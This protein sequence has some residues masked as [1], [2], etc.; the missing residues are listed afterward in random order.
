MVLTNIIVRKEN[1]N[2][3]RISA[4][5]PE[6]TDWVLD[7]DHEKEFTEDEFNEIAEQAIVYALE[8]EFKKRKYA[9]VSSIETNFIY[10]FLVSKGFVA[11]DRI[12]AAYYLEPYWGKESIKSSTLLQLIDRQSREDAP[13]EIKEGA[14]EQQ[15]TAQAQNEDTSG[16]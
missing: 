1:M 9:F 15:T 4:G 2:H 6:G 3:Y 10:E 13:Q 14:G 11:P 8:K 5:N 12:S 7:I 16:S